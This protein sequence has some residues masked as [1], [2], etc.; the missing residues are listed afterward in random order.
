[1]PRPSCSSSTPTSGPL[2]GRG[3]AASV[4]LHG[5]ALL[6]LAWAWSQGRVLPPAAI[7]VSI[8]IV[9]DQ[10]R[11]V[12]AAVPTPAAGATLPLSTAAP[13]TAAPASPLAAA[14]P[15]AAAA[16]PAARSAPLPA[17]MAPA[18]LAAAPAA[19]APSAAVSPATTAASTL[20]A[21]LATADAPP[22]AAATV[23]AADPRASSSVAATA[24]PAVAVAATPSASAP[25]VPIGQTGTPE[26]TSPVSENFLADPRDSQIASATPAAGPAAAS[27]DAMPAAVAAPPSPIAASTSVEPPT[28]APQTVAAFP[29]AP[30][31]DPESLRATLATA[32]AKLPCSRVE[33]GLRDDLTPVVRG[34]VASAQQLADLRRTVGEF[35]VAGEPDVAVEVLEEPFCSALDLIEAAGSNPDGAPAIGLNSPDG[36]FRAGD[37]VVVTIAV[38]ESTTQG[39]LQ[40]IYIDHQSKVVHLLPNPFVTATMVHGGQKV[41]LGVAAKDRRAGVRDY[42]VTPPF[43][44]GV[45]LALLSP[46]PL[47]RV[48]AHEVETLPELLASLRQALALLPPGS[49]RV[50]HAMLVTGPRQP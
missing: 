24:H 15:V 32:L 19:D 9:A 26:A 46:V 42:Q 5:L 18:A 45:V 21:P 16:V 25:P 43:G 34:R 36:S 31:V 10:P 2:A 4:L 49:L 35:A 48:G 27:A 50:A 14:A 22:V 38:P 30:A 11:T 13:V 8:E 23:L 20:A 39:Y 33:V 7:P 29:A 6:A 3:L 44:R 40:V 1:M 28:A 47:G 41:Q 17:R 12:L 37:Y